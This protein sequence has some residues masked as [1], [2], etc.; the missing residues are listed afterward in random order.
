MRALPS[1]VVV[2]LLLAAGLYDR[3]GYRQVW[4]RN[5]RRAD[6]VGRGQPV[7]ERVGR[8]PAPGRVGPLRA[9]FDLLAGPAA[10]PARTGVYWRGRLV[11]A[12]EATM[13]CCPDTAANLAAYRRGGGEPT[14]PWALHCHRSATGDAADVPPV[15]ACGALPGHPFEPCARAAAAV[16]I[17]PPS[18]SRTAS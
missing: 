12:V 16:A 9:L 6:R 4:A 5:V 1:R 2:Y 18:D 13:M 3:L 10:G 15:A 8:G 17:H 14:P 7:R 11:C